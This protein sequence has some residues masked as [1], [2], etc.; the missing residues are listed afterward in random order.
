MSC[1]L[2]AAGGASHGFLHDVVQR[3]GTGLQLFD[4]LL[5]LH[6]SLLGTAGEGTH[7]ICHHRKAAALLTGTGRFDGGVEG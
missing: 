6:R 7:F 2:L 3:A 5:D 4:H 1:W